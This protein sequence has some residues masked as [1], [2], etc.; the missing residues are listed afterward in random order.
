MV[1]EKFIYIDFETLRE[2]EKDCF[3]GMG[4]PSKDA[5]VCADV[6]FE[7]DKKGIDSHGCGRLFMF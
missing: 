4:V 3:V 2:F 7:A 6:L 1:D 5:E